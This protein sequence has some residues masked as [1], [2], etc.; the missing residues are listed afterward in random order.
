[1]AWDFK[2]GKPRVIK[3]IGYPGNY[4]FIPRTA[5][6]KKLGGDDEPLDVIVLGDPA[7]RGSVLETRLIGVLKFMDNGEQDDTLIAV[8]VG[9]PP[10]AFSNI[11]NLNDMRKNFPGVIKI[12]RTFF[13]NYKGPGELEFKGI[14]SVMYAKNV[15]KT[16]HPSYK[17]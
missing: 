8:H 11:K 4:D 12:I 16:A 6:P 15:L 10:S 9:S 1:M 13:Q 14:G 5:L 2:D 17:Q 7:P 3:Y